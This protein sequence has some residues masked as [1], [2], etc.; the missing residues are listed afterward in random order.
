MIVI[1]WWQQGRGVGYK[2]EWVVMAQWWWDRVVMNDG[3]CVVLGQACVLM[4]ERL[5][6]M[7]TVVACSGVTGRCMIVGRDVAMVDSGREVLA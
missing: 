1:R 2:A 7:G 3:G 4:V 6:V 5:M